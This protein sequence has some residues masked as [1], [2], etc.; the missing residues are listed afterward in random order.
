MSVSLDDFRSFTDKEVEDRVVYI[1]ETFPTRS[2][3]ARYILL[4]FDTAPDEDLLYWV[5]VGLIYE[6]TAELMEIT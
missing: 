4:C 1:M 6:H 5:A 2:Q 3:A